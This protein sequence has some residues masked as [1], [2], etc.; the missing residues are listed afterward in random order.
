MRALTVL[1]IAF[2]ARSSY[3]A[4]PRIAD[5]VKGLRG[6][7]TV[8]ETCFGVKTW[9]LVPATY[10]G[11][12]AIERVGKSPILRYRL[13]MA[14][15]NAILGCVRYAQMP[16]DHYTRPTA[17]PCMVKVVYSLDTYDSVEDECVPHSG[18]VFISKLGTVH[19]IDA[20]VR[21]AIMKDESVGGVAPG[22]QFV[23]RKVRTKKGGVKT[24]YMPLVDGFRGDDVVTSNDF[25]GLFKPAIKRRDFTTLRSKGVRD[26]DTVIWHNT[27]L[28]VIDITAMLKT[29][30]GG[31]AAAGATKSAE[32]AY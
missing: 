30:E 4:L 20:A 12:K 16:F 2:A 19:D 21:K 31:E 13:N 18:G 7:A 32:T 1:V 28:G 26:G 22:R 25:W 24:A 3:A 14:V 9:K 5:V 27:R 15:D 17:V 11:M 6:L 23:M 29:N 10:F 8:D